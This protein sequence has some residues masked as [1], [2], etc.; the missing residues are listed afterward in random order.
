MQFPLV[1]RELIASLKLLHGLFNLAVTALF[2]YHARNGLQIRR[3]RLAAG[4]LPLQAKKRHRR[5]GPLLGLLAGAGFLAGLILVLL[6][7]GKWLSFPSHL[8]TGVALLLVLL[9][10]YRVSRKISGSGTRERD[11]HYRLGLAALA[12]FLVDVCLGIGV[13]L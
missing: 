4:A 12:L 2:F 5:M 13:L 9:V 8:Y 1:S 11:L 7:T 10:S 6:D 3:A